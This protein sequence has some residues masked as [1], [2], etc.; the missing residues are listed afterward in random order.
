MF[1]HLFYIV[2]IIVVRISEIHET[3]KRFN[4]VIRPIKKNLLTTL[5]HGIR[6]NYSVRSKH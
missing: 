2:D 1:F 4:E 5:K 6:L 3:T